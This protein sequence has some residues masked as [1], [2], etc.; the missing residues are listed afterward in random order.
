MLPVERRL[1]VVSLQVAV[2]DSVPFTAELPAAMSFVIRIPWE[3]IADAWHFID[4]IGAHW[5][6]Q[7]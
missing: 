5:Q 1:H 6:L 2:A 7:P 3:A 4:L